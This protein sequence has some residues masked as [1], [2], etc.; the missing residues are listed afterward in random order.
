MI[1]YDVIL[2]SDGP[3]LISAHSRADLL[4]SRCCHCR[5]FGVLFRFV[6]TSTKKSFGQF[7]VLQLRALVLDANDES[8]RLVDSTDGGFSLVPLLASVT[9]AT[10]GGPFDVAFVESDLRR[11]RLSQHRDRHGGRVNA[12]PLLVGRNSLVAMAS[13]FVLERTAGTAPAY[14]ER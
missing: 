5:E 4:L 1:N 3:D 7:L 11:S 2:I 10:E 14:T 12:S 13:R 6:Q 8:R 9:G